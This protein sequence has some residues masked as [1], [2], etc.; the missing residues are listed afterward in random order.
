MGSTYH[1]GGSNAST[2]PRTGLT[3]TLDAG[4]LRQ[5]EN[6]YLSVPRDVVEQYPDDVRRL[7]GYAACPPLMGW[8]EIDGQMVDPLGLLADDIPGST[9][10]TSQT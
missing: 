7:L 6:H 1:A 5:E 2:A 8:I 10:S 9:I 4:F 3:M